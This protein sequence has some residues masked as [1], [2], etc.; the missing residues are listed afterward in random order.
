MFLV[1]RCMVC[2]IQ[3][4]RS[5]TCFT[6]NIVCLSVISESQVTIRINYDVSVMTL[7]DKQYKQKVHFK[8]QKLMS[9]FIFLRFNCLLVYVSRLPDFRTYYVDCSYTFHVSCRDSAAR[10][11][12]QSPY[13]TIKKTLVRNIRVPPLW[14]LTKLPWNFFLM[15]HWNLDNCRSIQSIII[16][17]CGE[18]TLSNV[19][20]NHDAIHECYILSSVYRFW[21]GHPV[22]TNTDGKI[23]FSTRPGCIHGSKQQVR[24]NTV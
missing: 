21:F 14:I 1:H 13:W 16:L 8:N 18:I 12:L 2:V 17:V 19:K 5:P 11:P 10:W 9:S 22:G 15:I 3:V 7:I 24:L 4:T 6:V 20:Y 23:L